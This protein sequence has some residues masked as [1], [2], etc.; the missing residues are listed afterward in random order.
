LKLA[1]LPALEQACSDAFRKLDAPAGP[2]DIYV[3]GPFVGIGW[4]PPIHDPVHKISA[5]WIGGAQAASIFVRVTPGLDCVIHVTIGFPSE[6]EH[7]LQVEVC[8]RSIEPRFSR[9]EAGRILLVAFVPDDLTRLHDGRLWVRL[10][11]RDAAG[12]PLAGWLSVMRFSISQADEM[13]VG[14]EPLVIQLERLIA[15]RDASGRQQAAQI[16]QLEQQLSERDA[17]LAELERTLRGAY[18]SRSWRLTAPLRKMK[19]WLP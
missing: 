3:A 2:S 12:E 10:A 18:E 4:G 9:D 7:R 8:G 17:K 19:K 6:L 1:A 13:A 14:L 5:R 16:S 11:C 15:D